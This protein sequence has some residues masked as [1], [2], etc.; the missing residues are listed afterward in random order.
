MRRRVRWSEHSSSWEFCGSR[1]NTDFRDIKK[2]VGIHSQ[3]CQG[4]RDRKELTIN[5]KNI[6][7]RSC[8]QEE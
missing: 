1:K 2:I 5:Y 3:D 4:N 6:E 7:C 8:K